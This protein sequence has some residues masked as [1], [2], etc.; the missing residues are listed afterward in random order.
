MPET[1]Y[2]APA[3]EGRL[4]HR[5][6]PRVHVLSDA[7]SLSLLARL[8]HPDTQGVAVHH[9]LHLCY[10]QLLIAACEQ[11]PTV[12]VEWPTR[13]TAKDPQ[14]RYV[15]RVIDPHHRVVLVDVARAGMLP[16]H[17]MQEVLLQMVDPAGV[18]VDHVYLQR[19]TDPATGHV[20]GVQHN[21]SKI[22]GPVEGATVFIPDP[23]AAT[24]HSASYVIGLYRHELGGPPQR[25]V[26]CHLIVTPEYLARIRDVAPEA[27]VYALRVD[28]GASPE[29]VLQTIPGT[30]WDRERG[31]DPNDYITPGAG[32]LGELIS[33]A[34]V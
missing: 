26:L 5:Y 10:R 9:L 24:G 28:R 29:E 30:H 1:A 23:M 15:G 7:A 13:M 4:V 20:G 18:R 22:G 27:E 12:P 19:V 2:L 34:W 25:I 32:G 6:G 8:A 33:N 16:A 14:A 21:G 17:W 11:L 3:T 31:L